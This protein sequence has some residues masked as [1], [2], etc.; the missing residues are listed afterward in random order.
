MLRTKH[1][2][3][4]MSWANC[5]YCTGRQNILR[6]KYLEG[7]NSVTDNSAMSLNL[8][9]LLAHKRRRPTLGPWT[10]HRSLSTTSVQ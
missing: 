8:N 10:L 4:E 9:T 1:L 2:G 6:T 5:M 7:E 3:S